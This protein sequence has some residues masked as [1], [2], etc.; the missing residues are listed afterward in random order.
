MAWVERT[1]EEV[2]PPPSG[3]LGD[4]VQLEDMLRNLPPY[5]KIK[6]RR[7]RKALAEYE[8]RKQAYIE[9]LRQNPLYKFVM[10]V[11]AFTNEDIQKYWKGKSLTPF[12]EEFTPDPIQMSPEDMD[13]LENRAKEN[14]MADLH[15]YCRRIR[16]VPMFR[17]DTA[18]SPPPS[19]SEAASDVSSA[20]SPS[21]SSGAIPSG[22]MVSPPVFRSS[23]RRFRGRTTK[24]AS[25]PS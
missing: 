12:I 8:S 25:E 6:T 2:D 16:A 17:K 1:F 19:P 11:A 5:M 4:N 10:Q 3:S 23:E 14:A 20:T 15:Q 9:N 18:P 21:S 22:G 7:A 13:Q 24:N